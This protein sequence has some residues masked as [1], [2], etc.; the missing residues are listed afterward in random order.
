MLSLAL[1]LESVCL[2]MH[3]SVCL[4]VKLT[5]WLTVDPS[6]VCMICPILYP[7]TLCKQQLSEAVE[8]HWQEVSPGVYE[9]DREE[10]FNSQWFKTKFCVWSAEIQPSEAKS[11]AI[12]N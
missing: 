5:D 1:G 6:A 12:I 4:S 11:K 3:V 7:A 8:N 9:Q 10:E 2:F